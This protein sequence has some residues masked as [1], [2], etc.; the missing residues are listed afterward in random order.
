MNKGKAVKTLEFLRT[1]YKQDSNEFVKALTFAIETLKAEPSV[2]DIEK[3]ITEHLQEGID[4]YYACHTEPVA[5][6]CTTIHC[7]N[8]ECASARHFLAQALCKQ[9][10][11][12]KE[13]KPVIREDRLKLEERKPKVKFGI[14]GEHFGIL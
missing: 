14:K 2:E 3:V 1:Y 11:L 13:D 6:A 7:I 8:M 12:V 4:H 9:A 10:I 5:C